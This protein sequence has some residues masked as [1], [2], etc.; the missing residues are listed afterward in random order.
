MDDV[1]CAKTAQDRIRKYWREKLGRFRQAHNSQ[2]VQGSSDDSYHTVMNAETAVVWF[3]A[4]DA[5][6]IAVDSS[7]PM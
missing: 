7:L 5:Q 2:L 3:R 1:A 6:K 4:S